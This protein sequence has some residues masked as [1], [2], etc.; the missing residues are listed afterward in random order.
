MAVGTL[1]DGLK[2]HV[3]KHP[4]D[5][6]TEDEVRQAVRT[7]RASV[8]SGDLRFNVIDVV[9]PEK[10]LLLAGLAT[11]ILEVTYQIPAERKAYKAK[12]G[13]QDL[14]NVLEVVE[15]EGVQPLLTPDDCF[16]AEEIAKA[17]PKV[18]ELLAERYGIIDLEA[19]LC[20]DPW[21]VHC[22]GDEAFDTRSSRL[23]QTFLY[24]RDS[25][26][27]NQYAHPLPV[28]PVVDLDAR[29]VVHVETQA[30]S[31]KETEVPGEPYNYHPSLLSGNAIPGSLNVVREGAA[32]LKP[33]EIVQPDGPSFQVD[34]QVVTWDKWNLRVGFNHREGLVLHDVRF[35]G[36]LVCWRASLVEMA[37]PYADPEKPFQRKCAFDVGDYGLG[38]C[39]NSLS[40]GCDCLG[41][42]HYFD[43]VLSNSEG[44]PY[45]VK[46][47]V[48]MHEEDDGILWKHVE[49]RTGHNQSRRSR[50]LVLSFICTV[51]NYEYLF[52]WYL[53][54]DGS[55]SLEIKLSGM[56]S[57]N[58]TESDPK[59]GTL[60]APG[61]NAQVHQHM[62]CARLDMAVG[63]HKNTVEEVD[64]VQAA[65]DDGNP[66]GNVFKTFATV[67]K[68]EKQA[69]R[70]AAPELARSWRIFNGERKNPVSKKHIGF[71]L[72][73]FVF[74]PA[75]PLLLC[76]KT[77]AVAKR[78]M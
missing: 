2:V 43:A 78:G 32:V 61:V 34:G 28:L 4:L 75:Q 38:Y 57:T 45:T 25:E 23:V 41:S 3:D 33:L 70:E 36:E 6:L 24:R 31:S 12:I 47:A 62:F 26:F 13:G 46:K 52:Y 5:P 58:Y 7:V 76:Q 15:L 71:K 9:E 65:S 27:D 67:L 17:D 10:K 51:V 66:Y 18:K 69:Q 64:V 35:D 59:H 73:P 53:K 72:L 68:S 30:L 42:I 63:G 16:L 60:V 19:N 1:D 54:Q 20:C 22:T 55:M 8:A 49:Y 56:L 29:Q 21:S 74:G 11:R 77:S 48:C 39:T 50:K 37:V 44:S 40:L 14:S